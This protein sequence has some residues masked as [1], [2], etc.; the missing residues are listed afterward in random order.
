[1]ADSQD[2]LDVMK[3]KFKL[4][5]L[6]LWFSQP[7]NSGDHDRA[8]YT[9]H[10]EIDRSDLPKRI[11][12]EQYFNHS[13]R[14]L[15]T[16]FFGTPMILTKAFDYFAE[17]DVKANLE[18]HSR[19]QTSLGKSMRSTVV[20]GVQLNNWA[21]SAKTNTLLHELMAVESIVEKKIVKRKTTT[22]FRGR[23]FYAIIPDKK[24]KCVTFYYSRANFMEGRSVARGMPLFIRDHLKLDP[25]FFCNSSALTEALEGDWDFKQRKFLSAEEKIEG[26]RLDEMENEAN[27]EIE[28]YIS[29]DHQRAL[30]L[31]DDSFV[32]EETRLTKGDAAPPAA[33]SD[34]LSDMTGSTRESKA[35]AY[36]DSA[37]K[38]VAAQYTSTI[39]NMNSDLGLK[40]DRIEQLELLLKQMQKSSC[41][42]L[43][44][45]SAHDNIS[46]EETEVDT[47][48]PTTPTTGTP[49]FITPHKQSK[50]KG[51]T[52][53][54]STS[55]SSRQ[56]TKVSAPPSSAT[57]SS[58]AR[59]AK[60][61]DESSL[62]RDDMSL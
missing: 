6:G 54:D 45:T 48:N 62:D 49:S 36:A 52:V 32:S 58:L 13:P 27:A 1:M 38:E 5:D 47:S 17:D 39:S 15:N 11:A 14:S 12:M 30:T 41:S 3:K 59:A 7:R 23:L 51:T 29:K 24:K 56:K 42:Q 9:L 53:E 25:S 34:E 55:H 43:T 33:K 60:E 46:E 2:F 57:R 22:S 40:D 61:T 28:V 21:D 8:K 35:K 18:N 31:D 19:K 4:Q 10:I 16:T 37:V 44:E 50:R 20:T 26:D